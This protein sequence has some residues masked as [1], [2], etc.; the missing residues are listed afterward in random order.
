MPETF[1]K[2]VTALK[3]LLLPYLLLLAPAS[4]T[5]GLPLSNSTDLDA[6]LGFKSGLSYQSGALASWNTTTNHCEWPGVICSHRHK[7]RVSALNLTSAGLLGYISPSIGNLT[8]LTSLDLS[9]NLLYGEIPLAIGRLSWL[10]YLDLSNNSF[11]G[12]MPWS[13]GQLHQLSY[14]YLANNSLQGEITNGLSNCTRLMSIKLDLNN[15]NGKIPD[16]FGGFPK[17]KSMSLGKNNFTGIIPQSLGNLSSL[18]NLFVNDNH[19]SGQI[20]DAL[21]KISS[22]EKLALQVNHLSGTIPGTILN[23]SSLIHIGMEENELHGRLPSDLG[24]ALPKIQYFIVALNRF[25]GSI[26]ASIANATTMR[27]IDLSSNNFSGIIP[28]EIGTLCSLNYLML[29]MNQLEASSAKDWGFIT[30]LTN[31]TRLR[32]VTLQNNR[33]GGALPSSITNLSAQLEDL[34]IGSNRISGKIPDGI[35]N[36]PKLIKLGLSSNHFSGPIPESIGRLR[37][38]QRLTIEN[39]LLHGIIPSSLGNLTRLQQLSLD[40]NSLEGSLPA[41]IGNLRQLTIATFSNNELIGPMPKEIFSL[42]SLSYVLDLSRNH[43]SNSLPSAIGGLTKLTYLYMHSNN[44]SGLLPDSLSNCQSLMEL[45]LDNN[46]FNGTIPV[47][48]SK[49]QGLVLLNLT[50]NSFFRAIPHDLGL[51]DGLKELYLAH[52]N[53]SEQIPKDLE[54]M[55]SLYWLDISFNNL[56]GQVPAQG[57]FANLTGFK[58]DGNDNLCGGIDELH[59]PSCPTK[60]MEHNQ[61]IHSVT[62]KVIIPIAITILVCFTLAAAFFYIRKKLRPSCMRTTRVAPPIDGMYPR[63]SYYELFQATNG[64]SDSNLV[65]TGRYGSVYKGTVMV[66]RSETTVAIKVFNLEQSGSSK[67]FVAEGK[68]ISKIRHRNLISVITCCS[69]SGLNQNDFK[70][71]VF[72]F[73]PHGDL[74]K[75]LHPEVTSS[76]SN[77]VKVLTLMQRLSIASDIAAALDY[78]HNSCQPTI[79]HCDFKPSNIL[80]GQD[81]VAHVGDL[82]LAKILTDPEGTQ[83]INSKSSVGLMGTIGYIAPEYAECGQISPSGDV[84]SFGIVLLEMF[85]G[86]APTNDMFTDGLTLQKY[87][88]TAYPAQLIDIADPLLLSTATENTMGE[89]NCVMSSVTRLALV[90]T[91]M[92]P[93]ERLCIRDVVD[94]MQTI[95]ASY[96]AEIERLSM[97]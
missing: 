75:W 38:L 81:M 72:E 68:A 28:P 91:R 22:L 43:F 90:C 65:G 73:M 86:K 76:D 32:A 62:Q 11:M 18:S 71:I 47:S 39:N 42:P 40:N 37:T 77:P 21:G 8:Y 66:K 79:V 93:S 67:S 74:E 26:P 14:L 10:S 51:M 16:W 55:A 1:F 23:I 24:N 82:G 41:S 4:S 94:N 80:L 34:D 69:C 9:C 97:M 57:V 45:R 70:A 50:K 95:K 56:D 64:F 92:K 12:E 85:T 29:Q 89:I 58:F 87:A 88:E 3:L 17:L 27:S 36:F 30:L 61:R 2:M 33:L 48:V 53:L 83:L 7:Q 19:L 52:N 20:P 96:V 54:N 78:L 5:Q 25:T 44:F 15:L 46:L 84:Y 49:M 13:I 60:P 6:L 35:S 59:L 63:I 31:C